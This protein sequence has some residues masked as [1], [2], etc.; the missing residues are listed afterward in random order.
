MCSTCQFQGGA[1][2]HDPIECTEF[3][4]SCHALAMVVAVE[5]NDVCE[6]EHNAVFELEQVSDTEDAACEV[7]VFKL[8]KVSGTEDAACELIIETGL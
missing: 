7:I 3:A 2:A 4:P 1:G 6:F 5:H 8:E